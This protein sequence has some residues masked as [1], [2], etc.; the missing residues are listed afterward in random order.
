MKIPAEEL[1]EEEMQRISEAFAKEQA[2]DIPRGWIAKSLAENVTQFDNA[3]LGMRVFQEVELHFRSKIVDEIEI[4]EDMG[5]WLHISVSVRG[6]KR[7]PEY[8]HLKIAKEIFIG[9]ERKAVQVFPP[10]AEHFTAAEVLHLFA[11]LDGDPLPD[12]RHRNGQL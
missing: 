8:E 4:Y 12:F 11:S 7:L 10:E 1:S 9:P 2:S 6:A 3:R 5:L